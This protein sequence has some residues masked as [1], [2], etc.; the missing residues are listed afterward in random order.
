MKKCK[1]VVVVSDKLQLGQNFGY[2]YLSNVWL[3]FGTIEE[4]F[5]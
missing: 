2:Y 1:R 4:Q 3:S 5:F